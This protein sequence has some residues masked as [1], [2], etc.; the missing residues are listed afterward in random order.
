MGRIGRIQYCQLQI[1]VVYITCTS[2]SMLCSNDPNEAS[3]TVSAHN[4]YRVE[5]LVM[6]THMYNVYS[7]V[8]AT[9]EASM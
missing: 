9:D 1:F 7:V 6:T 5:Q 4:A 8:N 2:M 3:I